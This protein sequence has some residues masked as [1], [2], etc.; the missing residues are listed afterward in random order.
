MK[1]ARSKA[2]G[3]SGGLWVLWNEDEIALKIKHVKK[4]FIHDLVFL[5][6]ESS[7]EMTAVCAI[8]LA[9]RKW[10]YGSN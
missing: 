3:F 1:W 10:N 6:N 7:W 4:Y 9:H 8:S 2:P 5:S